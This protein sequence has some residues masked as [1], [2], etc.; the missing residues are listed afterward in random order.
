MKFSHGFAGVLGLVGLA[1]AIS[2]SQSVAS[3][4]GA[5]AL[6]GKG[7]RHT[8]RIAAVKPAEL[9]LVTVEERFP[10]EG[11]SVLTRVPNMSIAAN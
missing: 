2:V 5:S 1:A 3:D 6:S 10:N 11:R 4:T 9:V 7:D 8:M